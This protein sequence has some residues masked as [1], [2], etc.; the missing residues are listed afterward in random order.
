VT[1][2]GTSTPCT[3]TP[4][5][6]PTTAT[7]DHTVTGNSQTFTTGIKYTGSC[8]IPL[9]IPG[10]SWTVS[11]TADATATGIGTSG[12]VS[13][14]NASLTP[15]TVYT[16]LQTISGNPPITAYVPTNLPTAILTC[17]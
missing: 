7:L 11:D 12:S 17:K 9:V 3:E 15:I 16:T 6:S 14:Q 10:Y 4:F 2:A 5:I 1:T 13:C 8:A